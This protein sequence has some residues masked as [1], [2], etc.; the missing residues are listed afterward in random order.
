MSILWGLLKERGERADEVEIHN[1]GLPT[2]RYST[3]ETSVRTNERVGMGLQPYVTHARSVMDQQPVLAEHGHLLCW[4]GRLDNARELSD[5]LGI[6][7]GASDSGLVLAAFL[8][9][10]ENCFTHL[11]GDWALSLWS[12]QDQTLYLARDP[13]GARTLFFS[14]RGRE[15]FW[16]TYLDTFRPLSQRMSLSREY[17]LR[18]LSCGPIRDVTPFEEISSV[19]PGH[20]VVFRETSKSQHSFWTPI[21]KTSIRYNHDADYEEQFR[22][23]FAQSV[24]RRSGEG[25]SVLA[26]LSGGMDSTSIVC[27]SDSLRKSTEIGSPILDTISFFDDSES[28][29]NEKFYFEITE[30]YRGKTGIH[31]DTSFAQRTFKP[32]DAVNGYYLFPGADSFSYPQE[33]MFD[34]LVW[35][36][37]Y[38]S[39]LSGIGGDE[40]LGGVPDGRPELADHLIA[41]HVRRFARQSMAWSLASRKPLFETIGNVLRYLCRTYVQRPEP[42]RRLPAWLKQGPKIS[43]HVTGLASSTRLFSRRSRPSSI[44]NAES[45]WSIMETLPHLN[46]QILRRPEYRYPYLDRDL[47]EYLFSIPREQILRP[48]RRRSLMRRAL[49]QIVPDEILERRQKAYQLR[50]PLKVLSDVESDLQTLFV[51]SRIEQ[52][53]YIDLP[54]FRKALTG[55][56][57]G[58]VDEWQNIV[59]V[60]AYELWLRSI[61]DLPTAKTAESRRYEALRH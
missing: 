15:I 29:L 61:E 6:E 23:L 50:A 13:A 48:G 16:G 51:D 10:G 40:I 57:Q 28:T 34:A 21:P 36:R 52:F 20:Y 47:M 12:K 44:D 60:I 17:A 7:S 59:R 43:T 56:G 19:L 38:R 31:I 41:L 18:Y 22:V 45:W 24:A 5:Q 1:L 9:W 33:Q 14:R 55:I 11:I 39:V 25:A 2:Q 4:D 30:R 54:L 8:R 35:S 26:Q 49:I 58:E 32:H 53:G 42:T 3:G 37:G 46:P 27:M